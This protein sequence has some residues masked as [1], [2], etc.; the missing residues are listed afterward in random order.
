ML[1]RV[2]ADAGD[3]HTRTGH[4]AVGWLVVEDLLTVVVLVVLP[5]VFAKGGAAPARRPADWRA[6]RCWPSCWRS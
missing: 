2:L 3:L 6:I 4:M 5:A 1:L